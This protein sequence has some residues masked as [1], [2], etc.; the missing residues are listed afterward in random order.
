VVNEVLT[1]EVMMLKA[2]SVVDCNEYRPND[3]LGDVLPAQFNLRAFNA[4]V[5]TF[6]IST[7]AA[8]GEGRGG[9]GGP[10]LGVN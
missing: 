5:T 2:G 9:T 1:G 6:D 3:S 8:G 7:W 4:E 10:A